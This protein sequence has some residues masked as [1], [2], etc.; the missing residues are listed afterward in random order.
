MKEKR[1]KKKVL[2]TSFV[3]FCFR[4]WNSSEFVALL[5]SFGFSCV[6]ESQVGSS[7]K[8]F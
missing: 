4:T 1:K 5:F 8:G 2:M 7:P 3:A 6:Y